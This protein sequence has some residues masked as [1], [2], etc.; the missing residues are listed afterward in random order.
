M[1]FKGGVRLPEGKRLSRDEPIREIPPPSRLLVSL[2]QNAGAPPQPVVE[3]GDQVERGQVIAR[4][5]GTIS[6]FLHAPASGRIVS[7]KNF[8][9]P[10]LGQAPALELETLPD[11][12]GEK[13][14]LP[15]PEGEISPESIRKRV[16]E[17]GIVGM[18]GAAFPTHIKLSPPGPIDYAVVNGAECE[19]YLTVDHRLLI[20]N[21]AGILRG[22][23]LMMKAVGA[24]RGILAVEENK[25]VAAGELLQ[26]VSTRR[27]VEVR[28]L[29]VKYPQGSEKQLLESLLDREVPPGRLPAD[30][31]CVVQ[32]V[33]TVL[34]VAQAVDLGMPLTARVVTVSGPAVENPGNFLVRLG[35]PFSTLLA[36]AGGLKEGRLQLLAGGPMMGPAQATLE[37]SVL[38]GTSGLLALPAP[39]RRRNLA[40]LRCGACLRACPMG[41]FPCEVARAAAR[42]DVEEFRR[43][44][45]LN[46]LECG[47]CSFVCPSGRDLVQMIQMGKEQLRLGEGS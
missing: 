16:L 17:A 12:V 6:A 37:A 2:A 42:G 39:R 20:E 11:S 1:T 26:L 24:A 36:A 46:C 10:V 38:K 31:G 18:G 41:L 8:P 23:E 44:G 28:F 43:Q 29:E 45:G 33:H 47:C 21:P 32:N 35:T 30:V 25:R 27:D 40:C 19:P 3:P 15:L 34:A 9:H 7:L 4:P 14:L 13:R 5:T 22:L